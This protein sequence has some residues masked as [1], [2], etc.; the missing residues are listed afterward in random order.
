MGFRGSR[1]QIPPSRFKTMRINDLGRP[2][3]PFVVSG[4]LTPQLSGAKS[5]LLNPLENHPRRDRRVNTENDENCGV[6]LVAIRLG[7]RR[8]RPTIAK[9]SVSQLVGLPTR[10]PSGNGLNAASPERF[11]GELRCGP[12]PRLQVRSARP[13]RRE[14]RRVFRAATAIHVARSQRAG[15]SR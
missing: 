3:P 9:R 14:G 12:R 13:I 5:L 6:S 4:K 7:F 10:W 15:R 11:T 8:G 2:K 1:V